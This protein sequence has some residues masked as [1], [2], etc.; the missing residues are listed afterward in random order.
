MIHYILPVIGA[1]VTSTICGFIFI[2]V[3]Q[4][5]KGAKNFKKD[6]IKRK[7]CRFDNK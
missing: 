7:L 3:L 5:I 1:F 2:P 6:T 4:N